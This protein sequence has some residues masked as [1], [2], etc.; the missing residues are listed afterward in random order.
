MGLFGKFFDRFFMPTWEKQVM[1]EAAKQPT[2][3]RELTKTSAG[4]TLPL[5]YKSR[6]VLVGRKVQV[7]V[8]LGAIKANSDAND[9]DKYATCVVMLPGEAPRVLMCHAVEFLGGSVVK[10]QR[11]GPYKRSVW[12]ETTAGVVCHYKE[13]RHI[14]VSGAKNQDGMPYG[15]WYDVWFAEE[16]FGL[17]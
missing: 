7:F 17:A 5:F 2:P 1:T 10:S 9:P 8:D 12:M 16:C 3:E 13:G 11:G 15:E 14:P 6:Q 4:D